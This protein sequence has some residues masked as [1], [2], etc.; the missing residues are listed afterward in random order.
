ML[1]SLAAMLITNYARLG[2]NRFA[3]M[4]LIFPKDKMA[5]VASEGAERGASIK[6]S[7]SIQYR[8]QRRALVAS[9]F[10][11]CFRICS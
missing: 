10:L 9:A 4:N 3:P 7:S 6:G 1:V 5:L 8:V 2:V 11:P